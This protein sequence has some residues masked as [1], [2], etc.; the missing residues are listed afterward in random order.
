MSG[1]MTQP[2]EYPKCNCTVTATPETGGYC[3]EICRERDTDD[4]E[5]EVSCECGHPQCDEK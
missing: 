3:S 2:C 4:E 5:M 1:T